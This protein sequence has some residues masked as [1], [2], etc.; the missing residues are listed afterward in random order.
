MATDQ[1][2]DTKY[3]H[4]AALV[5]AGLGLTLEKLA[6]RAPARDFEFYDLERLLAQVREIET[7]KHSA[8]TAAIFAAHENQIRGYVA[9]L[10]AFVAL[11]VVKS[12][13]TFVRKKL[14]TPLK[15]RPVAKGPEMLD[16]L[17][18][19]SWGLW[20]HDEYGNLETDKKL[21]LNNG[22]ADFFVRTRTGSLW[23]DCISPVGT[24][25]HASVKDFIS[26]VVAE[27]WKAKFGARRGAASLPA[28]VAVTLLK[29]Q[30]EL[31]PKLI[32]DDIVGRTYSAP[33]ELWNECPGLQCVWFGLQSWSRS[34]QRPDVVATWTR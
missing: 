22:D 1:T 32:L 8:V 13:R 12:A 3:P 30:G 5:R 33:D 18:E 24:R 6:D 19:C 14:H 15:A 34:A 20:L 23:V 7:I 16:T 9:T 17:V 21:P 2:L 25:R 4:L 11:G 31:L 27:K 29:G 28:A 26:E 10:E